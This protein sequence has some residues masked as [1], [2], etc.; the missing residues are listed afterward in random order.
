MCIKASIWQ[1]R[2]I[3]ISY[4]LCSKICEVTMEEKPEMVH[5]FLTRFKSF[6][7]I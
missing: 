3:I 2:I 7:H 5:P 6:E 1:L 4:A